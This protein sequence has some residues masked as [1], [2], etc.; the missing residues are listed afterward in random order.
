MKLNKIFTLFRETTK[1]F[2][3]VSKGKLNIKPKYIDT[4]L[5]LIVDIILCFFFT[6]WRVV[7]KILKFT[8]VILPKSL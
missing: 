8:S 3:L 7:L 2:S 1:I 6:T 5:A 4:F